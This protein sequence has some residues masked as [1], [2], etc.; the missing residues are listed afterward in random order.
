MA[1]AMQSIDFFRFSREFHNQIYSNI[2]PSKHVPERYDHMSYGPYMAIFAGKA[3]MFAPKKAKEP[4]HPWLAPFQASKRT[5]KEATEAF[6]SK[7]VFTVSM[8]LMPQ[9]PRIR[10]LQLIRNIQLRLDSKLW[11][12]CCRLRCTDSLIPKFTNLPRNPE[13]EVSPRGNCYITILDVYHSD[14]WF[15]SQSIWLQIAKILSDAKR[16][17]V[18]I[19]CPRWSFNPH[20]RKATVSQQYHL[21]QNYRDDVL[22]VLRPDLGPGKLYYSYKTETRYI[23][24]LPRKRRFQGLDNMPED[25]SVNNEET[26]NEDGKD[27]ILID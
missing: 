26:F 27:G 9:S 15:D 8:F 10:S 21:Y 11:N 7:G 3:I 4:D 24:F 16:V 19:Q 2:L 23:D 18:S 25:S 1:E 6:Y 17:I 5:R 22:N 12:Y 14:Q 13:T 20:D